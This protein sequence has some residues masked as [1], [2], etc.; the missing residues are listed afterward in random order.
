[1]K[2]T[3]P[4]QRWLKAR[5][6]ELRKNALEIGLEQERDLLRTLEHQAGLAAEEQPGRRVGCNP[7]EIE[8]VAGVVDVGAVAGDQA[9]EQGRVPCL[10]GGH[11]GDAAYQAAS[12]P[13]RHSP[14][15]GICRDDHFGGAEVSAFGAHPEP[16][17]LACEPGDRA[18]PRDPGPRRLHRPAK[19]RVI[20]RGMHRGGV[21][22]EQGATRS[23]HAQLLCEL[24]FREHA[25]LDPKVLAL[26]LEFRR[27]LVVLG[28]VPHRQEP[29]TVGEVAV[30]R[31][32]PHELDDEVVG[33][34]RAA[35][36]GDGLGESELLRHPTEAAE[37]APPH[38]ARVARA[39][40]LARHEAIEHQHLAAG[41]G[42]RQRGR[43][44]GV[45]CADHEHASRS[46]EGNFA[47]R[48]G[49]GR[50]PPPGIGGEVVANRPVRAHRDP[51]RWRL[52]PGAPLPR[53][54]AFM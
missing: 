47:R 53:T 25:S 6:R 39:R 11:G 17:R 5:A 2:A 38:E 33:V 26:E 31:E 52:T 14:G 4:R 15:V 36:Q 20:H 12:E 23:G 3:S 46:G 43:K 32:T 10:A 30:D 54:A 37:E 40:R 18:A 45:A 44:T 41:F 29:A 16:V 21:L 42:Q 7:P 34:L 1:M 24:L 9:L 51:R 22:D 13:R 27:G 35:V 50:L 19:A 49:P 48:P 8:L 28:L